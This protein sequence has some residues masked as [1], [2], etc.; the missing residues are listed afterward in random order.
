MYTGTINVDEDV[1]PSALMPHLAECLRRVRARHITVDGNRITFK[2]GV[3]RFVSNWN[4]LSPFGT[5]ELEFLPTTRQVRYRLSL[6]QCII[7]GTV[8]GGFLAVLML[9]VPHSEPPP[10][11]FVPV[12]LVFWVLLVGVSL[13]IGIGRFESFLGESISTAPKR[14]EG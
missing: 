11:G 5:G 8:I 9:C 2:G 3:F 13:L 7:V 10:E 4:V 14:L 1:Q 6:A 12:A